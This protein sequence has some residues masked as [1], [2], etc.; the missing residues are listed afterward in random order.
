MR[1]ADGRH[2]CSLKSQSKNSSTHISSNKDITNF[3]A[4]LFRYRNEKYCFSVLQNEKTAHSFVK[5]SLENDLKMNFCFKTDYFEAK[6]K[7]SI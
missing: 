5:F 2:Q 1:R 7:E 3:F 4:N 6:R